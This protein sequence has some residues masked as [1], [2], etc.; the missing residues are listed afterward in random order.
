MIMMEAG[1]EGGRSG[2][3]PSREWRTEGSL[4]AV[5]AP[6]A[7]GTGAGT[8][9]GAGA[10]TGTGTGTGPEA[11]A[12]AAAGIGTGAR[13]GIGP[14]KCC[15]T[16]RCRGGLGLRGAKGVEKRPSALQAGRT[17]HGGG[18][19]EGAT[20]RHIGTKRR[21]GAAGGYRRGAAGYQRAG[22][23]CWGAG[24]MAGKVG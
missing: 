2:S 18:D 13:A 12:G 5:F 22:G 11:G 15:E 1:G 10:G 20:G 3:W 24:P 21:A 16:D 19:P 7:I 17:L 23:G 4:V 9:T 8:R 14:D 6:D